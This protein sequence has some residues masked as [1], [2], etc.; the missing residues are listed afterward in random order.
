MGTY[1]KKPLEIE[2]FRWTGDDEQDS[3]PKWI[4]EAITRG[5]VSFRYAG[6][7]ECEMVIRTLEGDMT[8]KL[9]DYII[10]GIEGE[11]YPCKAS[12]FEASYDKVDAGRMH[13]ATGKALRPWQSRVLAELQDLDQ[14]IRKLGDM[15]NGTV[16]PTPNEA[17]RLLQAQYLT[18]QA[19]AA[20]LGAR[21]HAFVA[22]ED[23]QTADD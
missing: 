12:I 5:E 2:A 3:E 16:M 21:I 20:I 22:P 14:K 13:G 10:R 18:M 19:Y 15:L 9:G 8:A 6:T 23:P 1:V 4:V 7:S 17:R 11:L